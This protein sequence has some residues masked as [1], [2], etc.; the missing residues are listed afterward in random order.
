MVAPNKILYV[1]VSLSAILLLFSGCLSNDLEEKENHEAE[2]IQEFL[3]ANGISPESK[4]EGGI[5]YIED[6]TGTGKSPV[7]DD[8]I[9]INYVGRYLENNAIHETSYDSLKEEWSA[10]AD[11]KY[12]VYGPSKFQY[13]YSIAGLNEGISMMKEGGKSTMV[14][15][16][17]KAFYDYNPLVYSIELLKVIKDPVQH[18][19]SVLNIY[20]TE[21]GFDE[22]TAYDE[23]WFR[24][25]VTPDPADI[26]TVEPNDTVYFMFTGRLVDGYEPVIKDDRIFDTS[27]DDG[28]PIKLVYSTSSPKVKSGTILAIPKGLIIALDSMR[29]G[30]HA[31]ALLPYDQA[32]GDKGLTNTIYGYNIVPKYQTV[33]Y[34]IEVQ[35][36]KSPAGK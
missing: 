25:T 20:R 29:I 19:D 3:T 5:Y 17:D 7:V 33:V 11:F 27:E 2:L 32:F 9:V 28:V 31:T 18:E 15:P 1:F 14:I 30:T 12:F 24:E 21:K 13:G 35:D 36:I 10:A 34:D 22:S 6:K 23:I 8:Y 26:R 16:S 4:T